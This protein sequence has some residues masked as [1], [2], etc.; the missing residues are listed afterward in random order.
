M[1]EPATPSASRSGQGRPRRVLVVVIVA[2][3]VAAGFIGVG[4]YGLVH[5]PGTGTGDA[6]P[7]G[8][9]STSSPA[10]TVTAPTTPGASPAPVTSTGDPEQFARRVAVAVFTWDTA[11]GYIPSDYI[12]QIVNVGDPSGNETP[13]LAADLADYLPNTAAWAQLRQYETRQWLTIDT[14]T[15]PTTWTQALQQGQATLLPGTTAYTITGTR[16]RAGVW[17]GKPVT[18]AEQVSFTVFETCQPTYPTCRVLRLSQL[19]KPLP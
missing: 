15:V 3:V 1:D 12:Q 8:P 4:V 19:D 9:S 7:G 6:A 18:T 13:G 5:G 11:T 2:L 14:A 10:P 16:R 17:D